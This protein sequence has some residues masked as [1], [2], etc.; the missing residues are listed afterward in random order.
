MAI[1]PIPG[2]KIKKVGIIAK[3]KLDQRVNYLNELVKELEKSGKEIFFDEVCARLLGL[4]SSMERTTMMR[5]ADLVV[6][7]GGDGTLLKSARFM[8]RKKPFIAGVNMGHLG[9]L[10]AFT[11]QK[12]IKNLPQVFAGKFSL[13]ER[14]LLRV[15][16][17]RNGKKKFTTLAI[18]EAVINQGGFARLINLHVEVN[19]RELATYR[20]D[21]L[22]ISTPTGSTGHA[23]S[24]GGP[25]V[26][27]K[28]L[29]MVMTPICPIKLSVRPI[30]IP[31]D[32]Q[33]TI[34]LETEWRAE[35]KPIV[36]T[37]DG[38]I[39]RNLKRGD[40]IK[41]R[42]SSRSFNMIRMAGHN[43]YRMLRQKLLWTE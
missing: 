37:I 17:Y 9:F 16:V 8:G 27:P 14:F 26:H 12:F 42:K 29:G 28:I 18:N 20:A 19:Q 6:V 7:L 40:V 25:I 13:D 31:N 38:Q 33:L 32:R 30:I 36:L 24:A 35:K 4:K 5:K 2:V 21:G 3:H 34:K 39:T 22:I 41:I 43:Y 10:T 15:T 23:L 11:P 1:K